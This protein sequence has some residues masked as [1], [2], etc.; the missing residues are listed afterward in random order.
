M[1]KYN[2]T[3]NWLVLRRFARSKKKIKENYE[4]PSHETIPEKQR[5]ISE[6]I[7]L[8]GISVTSGDVNHVKHHEIIRH[9][10]KLLTLKSSAFGACLSPEAPDSSDKKRS[11]K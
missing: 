10:T 3:W 4:S 1:F 6:I 5:G 9:N 7:K 2:N 8:Y 11:K